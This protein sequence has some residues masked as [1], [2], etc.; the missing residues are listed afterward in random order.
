[1]MKQ[2][3]I[4]CLCLL[5]TGCGYKKETREVI[6]F[7]TWGSASEMA[8]LK[9]IISEFES[10]NPDIKVELLHIP[11]DYFQKLHLLFA[12]NLAPDVIFI[13]NLNLPIY[14][15]QLEE[16]DD[17]KTKKVYYKQAIDALSVNKHLFAIPRDVST[18]VIYYNKSMFSQAGVSFPNKNWTLDDLFYTA[19]KMTN[20]K[21]FGISYEPLIYYALPF[22]FSSD[23][24]ILSNDFKYIG[25]SDNSYKGVN[26]YKN[27]AYKYHCAPMPSQI[28]SK[29]LAQ[30]FLEE[31][32]AMHLSGRWL[33]PKYRSDANFDWDIINFPNYIVPC[34]A[35]GWAVSK[36]S[37]HKV[38]AKKFVLFLSDKHNIEKFTQS[39]L[40]VPARIDVAESRIFLS[41]KPEHSEL[42]LYT[43]KNSKVTP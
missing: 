41:G 35:S 32:V 37:K 14:S 34:D 16:L 31:R 33:V 23:G 43:V 11:Q 26:N 25:D 42:F 3:F 4:L 2:F 20:D 27:L 40:I 36:H 9:P 15:N 13:N 39:G 5:L 38:A 22:M 21:H 19:V 29:T 18:L 17:V 7:S 1:M 24:G 30:M 6:K 8:I 28:G 10:I 12:S